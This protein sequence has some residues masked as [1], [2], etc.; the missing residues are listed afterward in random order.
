MNAM[1]SWRVVNGLEQGPDTLALAVNYQ[2]TGRPDAG[3]DDLAPQLAAGYQVW[4]TV[5]PPVG[6]EKD[7]SGADYVARWVDGIR[8]SDRPVRC[9][10]GNCAGS[11]YAP[12]LVAGIVEYQD[13][14]PEII[15]FDPEL[16]SSLTLY[17]QYHSVIAASAALLRPEEIEKAHTAG[18]EAMAEH[19][20]MGSYAAELVSLFR[21]TGGA[22]FDRIGLDAVRQEGL[23]GLFASYL[24]YLVAA[25]DVVVDDGWRKAVAISST[26]PH[27]GLNRVPEAERSQ[28]VGREIRVDVDHENLL[29]S[30]EVARAV[31]ELLA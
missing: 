19:T 12:A 20:D 16:P 21:Q 30:A 23:V 4:E 5:P 24:S 7:L 31:S 26:T 25:S 17:W 2:I 14:E 18:Q 8:E 13:V 22:A 10:L 1:R 29:R 28:W 15:L 6:T 3:F 9:V 11:A 27:S